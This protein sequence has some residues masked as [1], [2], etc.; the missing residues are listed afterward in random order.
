KLQFTAN[1]AGLDFMCTCYLGQDIATIA[2]YVNKFKIASPD[3][4]NTPFISAHLEYDKEIIMSVGM[5]TKEELCTI[6]GSIKLLHCVSAYPCPLNQLN[7]GA[8]RES[9]LDG[10]SDHSGDVRVGAWAFCAGANI[11]EVHC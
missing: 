11:L 5:L 4:L 2:P 3:A 10:F 9:K 6:T 8:I 1:K 7:L